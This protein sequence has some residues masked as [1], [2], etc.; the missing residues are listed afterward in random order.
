[1]AGPGS[2]KTRLGQVI[3]FVILKSMIM[4]G[5]T[6]ALLTRDDLIGTHVGETAAKTRKRLMSSLEG[7]LFID[8]AYALGRCEGK[9]DAP[10]GQPL[11][12][13]LTDMVLQASRFAD[14]ERELE[15]TS[16]SIPRRT[17]PSLCAGSSGA[18]AQA[19]TP[20]LSTS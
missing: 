2:G 8:E 5:G 9:Q 17:E 3:A 13:C 1:M 10:V 18:L 11:Q 20:C 12:P 6:L 16:V 7:I 15:S 19:G 14:L 4:S